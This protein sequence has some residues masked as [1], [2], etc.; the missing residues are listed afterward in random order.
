MKPKKFL[1]ALL[2]I[3][4]ILSITISFVAF[5]YSYDIYN[6]ENP[7][8]FRFREKPSTGNINKRFAYIKGEIKNPGIYQIT[9]TTRIID[10]VEMANGFTD[11][12][13]VVSSNINLASL[14]NDE[15]MITIPSYT[16][17]S[18]N[19]NN[20]EEETQTSEVGKVSINN[21]TESQLITLPGIGPS[22]A[23]KIIS[24]RPYSTISDLA[25]V[26]GIGKK[27]IENI[28]DLITL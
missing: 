22:T 3:F 26:S 17:L 11:Y 21:A 4:L 2:N 20:N 13:D 23:S 7:D 10:L 19:Q 9:E 5:K 28:S 12:A 6:N 1:K 18:E 24:G 25:S 16:A 15:E 8:F 27:T 14:V